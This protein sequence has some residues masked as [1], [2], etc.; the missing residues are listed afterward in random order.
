MIGAAVLA[1]A[2]SLIGT[3]WRHLGRNAAGLDCIGLVWLA[4]RRAGVALPEP[5]PYA[6]EPQDQALRAALHLHLDPVPLDQAGPGDVLLFNMGIY[7]GHVGVSSVHPDY[8]VAS[9]VHAHL[10]RHAV[11]EELLAP[12]A[13]ELTGAFRWRA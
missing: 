12:L 7:A 4:A 10:P 1:E 13:R 6:R 8:G 3:R 5:E 2:R 11:V 9:L